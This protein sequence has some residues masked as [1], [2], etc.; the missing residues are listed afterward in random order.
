MPKVSIYPNPANKPHG[1]SPAVRVGNFVYVSGQLALGSK[2]EI[3]GGSDCGAQARQCFN[4]MEAVLGIVPGASMAKVVK[5]TAFLTSADNYT[6]Y[7]KAREDAFPQN[8]PASSTVIVNALVL[9]G[10]LVEVEA[11]AVID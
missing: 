11:V 2:D 8:A 5:I 4:N 7:A 1:Y 3:V 10:C 9:K 6:A